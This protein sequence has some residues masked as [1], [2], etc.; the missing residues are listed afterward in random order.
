LN[1]PCYIT[2]GASLWPAF[3]KWHSANSSSGK[4]TGSKIGFYYLEELIGS[5]KLVNAF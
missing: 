5:K 2:G 1:K 3:S 4:K